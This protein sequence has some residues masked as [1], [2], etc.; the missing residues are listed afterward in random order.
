MLGF[1]MRW[2]SDGRRVA[3]REHWDRR[4]ELL[5]CR[6]ADCGISLRVIF[7]LFL[8]VLYQV[9][10]S[11]YYVIKQRSQPLLVSF[12]DPKPT[13]GLLPFCLGR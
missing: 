5:K 12:L 13:N 8:C 10:R 4:A 2:V 1:G 9:I 7:F 6:M 11:Q 3:V